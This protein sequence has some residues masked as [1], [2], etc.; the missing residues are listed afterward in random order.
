M[1]A[2]IAQTQARTLTRIPQTRVLSSRSCMLVWRL[3]PGK[4]LLLSVS[5]GVGEEGGELFSEY[6][7]RELGV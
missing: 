1:R 2:C 6:A 7:A 5:P 4:E 3:G